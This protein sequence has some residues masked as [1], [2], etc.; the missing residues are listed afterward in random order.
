MDR[1]ALPD[2]ELFK[3]LRHPLVMIE[4][5]TRGAMIAM[6]FYNQELDQWLEAPCPKPTF[7]QMMEF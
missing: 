1:V 3:L 4:H 5:R 7:P 6:H 2:T